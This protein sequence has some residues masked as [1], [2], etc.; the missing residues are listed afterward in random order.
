MSPL[1]GCPPRY[2]FGPDTDFKT[3]VEKNAFL[4]RV[5]TPKPSSRSSDVFMALK[6][7]GR[8]TSDVCLPSPDPPIA[9]YAD[10]VRHMDW[11]TRYSSPYM[12]TSFSFMWAVWEALRRY[13]LGVKHDVEIA[14][15][16]ATAISKQ[17]VT[18]VEL[19]RGA[20]SVER[21]ENHWKW[22][23]FA[24]E[25]QSVLVYGFIPQS[26]VLASVP[27][28]WIMNKLPSY[29][30]LPPMAGPPPTP[31]HHV[32]WVYIIEKPNFR[33][34]CEA[35]SFNFMRASPEARFRDSTVAAVRLSLAFLSPWFYW[36]L[37]L[38]PLRENDPDIFR[39]AAVTKVS[40]LAH[41]IAAW[42]AAGEIMQIWDIVIREI[43]VLIAEEV[44]AHGRIAGAET[45]THTVP[46]TPPLAEKP[47]APPSDVKAVFPTG[48]SMPPVL[49]PQ[50]YL[51][52]P[53]PTPPP[54]SISRFP[55]PTERS[56]NVH[57]SALS[58]HDTDID[59]GAEKSPDT[60]GIPYVVELLLPPQPHPPAVLAE[61]SV[62]A[63]PE[64]LHEIVH[65][66]PSSS[67]H[68]HFHSVSETASCLLTGFL[69]GA[70]II[71]VLSQRRPILIHLS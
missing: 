9:T 3:L 29:C 35:L 20:N 19:M 66:V 1:P 59:A 38:H 60:F 10:V 56:P 43:A 50:N 31:V 14:I 11:T 63:A 22:Y 69:F 64:I 28:L 36:M 25:S 48:V 27:I 68:P 6:F 30:L 55:A 40:E 7:D 67:D 21:H 39:D 65:P 49:D 54:L 12:S 61:Q 5:H 71:I 32:H 42:P 37:Q 52:T 13:H 51:L 17:S 18:V 2:S 45:E 62:D 58:P 41:A 8:Y 57:T 53:P 34:F 44:K 23:H 46:D 26:A 16:D 70:L 24:Q 4:F 47:S 15:I 33:R